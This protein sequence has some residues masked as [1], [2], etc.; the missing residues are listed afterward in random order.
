MREIILDTETTGL[1]ANGDD[2]IIE[3]ACLEIVNKKIT[4]NTFHIY[5]NPERD[6]PMAATKIHNI[7]TDFLKDKPLFKDVA[8]DFLD[9]IGTDPLVI[10]NAPFD[11]GFINAELKRLDKPLLHNARALC[12][13]AMAR[14]K[15]PGASNT[16]DALCKR[17]KIDLSSRTFHGALVDCELL[18]QVYIEL[19]GGRQGMFAFAPVTRKDIQKVDRQEKIKK[20]PRVFSLT[21]QEEEGHTS[22]IQTL[23]DPL[24]NK[25]S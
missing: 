12:T 1:R 15:F 8:N 5:V 20:E 4:N 3:I 7:T 14:Q 6:V 16:L 19:M 18:V 13:L 22:F 17:F 2:R 21:K 9:F 10:H 25:A 24:W 23:K 11:M